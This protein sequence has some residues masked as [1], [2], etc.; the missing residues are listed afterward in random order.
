MTAVPSRRR[1]PAV[2]PTAPRREGSASADRHLRVATAPR[3]APRWAVWGTAAVTVAA[4][5]VLV[6]FHVLA[7]QHAFE[8]DDL[9]AQRAAEERHYERLRVEVATLSSP[10]AIVEAARDLGMVRAGDVEYIDAPPAAPTGRPADRT[11]DT[12]GDTW[13]AAKPSLGP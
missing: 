5:F 13:D 12:L 2:T 4:L 10:T 6:S 8:L 3:R 1:P 7:V 9:A 11:S